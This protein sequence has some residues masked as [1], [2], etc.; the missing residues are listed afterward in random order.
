MEVCKVVY[1]Y[2]PQNG[3]SFAVG[4]GILSPLKLR[5]NHFG[6]GHRIILGSEELAGVTCK[7]HL[8]GSGSVIPN[9][10]ES[11]EIGKACG[12]DPEMQFQTS[13]FGKNRGAG[14]WCTIYHHL[15]SFTC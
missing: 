5:Q 1:Q 14:D 12:T 10:I 8:S 7:C 11:L 4:F 2:I 13:P 6:A 3:V 9:I 15:S